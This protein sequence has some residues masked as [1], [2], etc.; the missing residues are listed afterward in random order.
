[1]KILIFVIGIITDIIL[2]GLFY[3]LLNQ[4][5]A[6]IDLSFEG[7]FDLYKNTYNKEDFVAEASIKITNGA[8]KNVSSFKLITESMK[9]SAAKLLLSKKTIN[10]FER[11]LLNLSFGSFE[12]KL[13]IRDGVIN[14]PKMTIRSNAL[15]VTLEGTH[16][17]DNK[18]DYSFMFR[19]REIK[20]EASSEFGDIMDDGTGVKVFLKMNGTVDQPIFSWDKEAKKQEKEMKRDEAKE[21]LKSALKSGFG[22]NK[23]DTTVQ[24]L[25]THEHMEEKLI[26][27]FDNDSIEQEFT[28]VEKKKKKSALQKRIDKWKKENKEG[29]KKETFEIDN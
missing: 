5:N 3:L 19:F 1:M 9:E 25:K 22:I 14:I 15:D 7:P 21:D 28:E 23:N 2:L 29:D 24:E 20:G 10:E 8:L 17:F 18:V 13:S 27:D 26:M 4:G 16:T 6:D 12:N 11:K